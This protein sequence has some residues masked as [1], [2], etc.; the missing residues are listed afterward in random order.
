MERCIFLLSYP[1][2][3]GGGRVIDKIT[4]TSRLQMQVVTDLFLSAWLSWFLELLNPTQTELRKIC[5][6]QVQTIEKSGKIFSHLASRRTALR[7]LFLIFIFQER[8]E[9]IKIYR[10]H[11]NLKCRIDFRFN[12]TESRLSCQ[13]IMPSWQIG[14]VQPW[15]WERKE[16]DR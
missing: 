3:Q 9:E 2:V 6:P 10:K 12:F 1:E 16:Q 5:W 15:R 8:K 14:N 13:M 11:T 7:H 4:C